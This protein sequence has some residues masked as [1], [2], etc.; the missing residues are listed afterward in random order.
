MRLMPAMAEKVF[1]PMATVSPRWW[2]KGGPAP[3]SELLVA[4]PLVRTRDQD[5]VRP[6]VEQWPA[7]RRA[8]CCR[9][10]E[11]PCR[12]EV[13]ENAL[14]PELKVSRCVTRRSWNYARGCA[15]TRELQG[16]LDALATVT[17][18]LY[19]ENRKLKQR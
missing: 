18:N 3:D 1:S 5:R 9:V 16:R 15:R 10:P 8:H 2:T 6:G 7:A 11:D 17:A 4:E 12:Q 19:F 13:R 14:R